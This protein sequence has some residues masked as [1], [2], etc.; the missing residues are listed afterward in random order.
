MPERRIREPSQAFL[1]HLERLDA[2]VRN[3]K[4]R[5]YRGAVRTAHAETVGPGIYD[6][7]I[8]VLEI[9]VPAGRWLVGGLATFHVAAPTTGIDLNLQIGAFDSLTDEPVGLTHDDVPPAQISF[10]TTSPVA[11]SVYCVGD[12]VTDANVKIVL[13]SVNFT[14]DAYTLSHVRL[15]LDPV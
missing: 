8:S 12:I 7:Y 2:D 9:V 14:G 10:S 4:L 1:Q 15:T 6:E 3:L 13:Q 5:A 11:M